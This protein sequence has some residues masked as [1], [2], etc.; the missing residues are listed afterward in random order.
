[1][2][3]MPEVTKSARAIPRCKGCGQPRKGHSGPTGVGKCLNKVEAGDINEN[4]EMDLNSELNNVN[5]I[6]IDPKD[7]LIK[8]TTEDK[9]KSSKDLEEDPQLKSLSIASLAISEVVSEVVNEL[10]KDVN[11][12]SK[13][14]S[15]VGQDSGK[16]IFEGGK[17]IFEDVQG[18]GK[19]MSGKCR[20]ASVFD[21]EDLLSKSALEDLDEV[22]RTEKKVESDDKAGPVRLGSLSEDLDIR[23]VLVEKT[24]LLCECEK[25]SSGD[26]HCT[27][28]LDFNAEMTGVLMAVFDFTADVLFKKSSW[29]K[30]CPN[31]MNLTLASTGASSVKG[32]VSLTAWRLVTLIKGKKHLGTEIEA[33]V[34]V[35]RLK[36][37]KSFQLIEQEVVEEAEG[38]L[39]DQD[40]EEKSSSE[41]EIP[42]EDSDI[43]VFNCSLP[44]SLLHKDCEEKSKPVSDYTRTLDDVQENCSESEWITNLDI[45]MHST[46]RK[47]PKSKSCTKKQLND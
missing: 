33:E 38:E 29:K 30:K 28:L 15:E 46:L 7:L 9:N 39:E 6:S 3:K 24:F 4:T 44:Q 1:V 43:D 11:D 18:S 10:N 36:F 35:K 13:K 26:C 16:K 21:Y 22:L 37:K 32:T 23:N 8:K 2:P 17:K 41:N 45:D 25:F 14:L 31:V 40:E 19:K 20:I 34:E 42:S 5:V 12:S 27:G 47:C